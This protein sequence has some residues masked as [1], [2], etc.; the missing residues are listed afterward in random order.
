[1]IEES[2]L[3]SCLSSFTCAERPKGWAARPAAFMDFSRYAF[4][5]MA[6]GPTAS[7]LP[8]LFLGIWPT[9][10]AVPAEHV[11]FALSLDLCKGLKMLDLEY[12]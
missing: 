10:D 4:Y 12:S 9:L 8:W 2:L 6:A 3:F 7:A 1:M 11:W 5:F